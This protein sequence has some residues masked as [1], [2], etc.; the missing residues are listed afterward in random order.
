[1]QS[2]LDVAPGECRV[3]SEDQSPDGSASIVAVSENAAANTTQ[4]LDACNEFSNPTFDCNTARVVNSYHGW[5]LH[6]T[7]KFNPPPPCPAGS[8]TFSYS[9]NG[10]LNIV[11]DQFP[12][13]NDNSYG[14]NAVGWVH[15]FSDLVGSDHAGFQLRDA[16]GIVRLSFNIDYITAKTGTPS[17]Y[18]SLGPFGGDG[19]VLVGALTAADLTFS[20]SLERNLN[21]LGYFSGGTQVVGTSGTNSASLL[22]NSPPTVNTTNDYTLKTPNPWVNGWDFHDTYFVTIKKAKLDAIGFNAAT[23]LVEPNLDQLHN[24]PAKPCPVSDN[25]PCD[26][27]ITKYEVKD[28]QVK[29]SI[30]NNNATVAEIL[31]ELSLT[32]PSATNGKLMQVKLDG[33]VIYDN[34]DIAGGSATLTLAQLAADP[35]KRKIDKGSTDVLTFIFENNADVVLSH[36]TS[37]VKFGDDCVKTILPPP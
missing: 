9:A 7:N 35:N 20:S 13:P 4:T 17:G 37:T 27:S 6:Y 14:I 2:P 15:K 28:K 16:G 5:T 22:V 3:A 19:K 10:D 18:A 21:N 8:F 1:V 36:Y 12:A 29:V 26:L 32:W 11:Y 23:W 30:A 33:D 24:S 25:G 31:T 34:P